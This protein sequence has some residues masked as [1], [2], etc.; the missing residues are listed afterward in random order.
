MSSGIV[1]S[2]T[3][4]C[5]GS[6]LPNPIFFVLFTKLTAFN[7]CFQDALPLLCLVSSF[8]F[9]ALELVYMEFL[10]SSFGVILLIPLVET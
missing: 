10:V 9:A 2:S 8:A 4:Y 6:F 5:S 3:I 7:T 1:G